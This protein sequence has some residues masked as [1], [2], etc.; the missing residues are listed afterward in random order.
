[1]THPFTFVWVDET[2]PALG[3]QWMANG[4][5]QSVPVVLADVVSAFRN[6]EL[7]A[8]PLTVHVRA[9]IEVVEAA[10]ALEDE[11]LPVSVGRLDQ[12]LAASDTGEP[13]IEPGS[14]DG[15]RIRHAAEA[16]E[17]LAADL[18]ELV[19]EQLDEGGSLATLP[20]DSTRALCLAIQ[21]AWR[22]RSRI[23]PPG[24]L[25]L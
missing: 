9:T 12:S 6:G 19:D 22:L 15:E 25:Y 23:A 1:V 20:P 14:D 7:D 8:D 3:G 24:P 5:G 17:K 10:G 11:V 4:D 13:E 18:A 21:T 2:E 16:L